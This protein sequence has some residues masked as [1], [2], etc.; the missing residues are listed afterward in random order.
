MKFQVVKQSVVSR[1][2]FGGVFGR[3]LALVR[4]LQGFEVMNSY[5]NSTT[6]LY[7]KNVANLNP[8]KYDIEHIEAYTRISPGEQLYR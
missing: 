6:K 8:R 5:Y 2:A 3:V 4:S 7:L 1:I